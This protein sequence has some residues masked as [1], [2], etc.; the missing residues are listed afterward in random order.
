MLR[1]S[2]TGYGLVA[3]TFHWVIALMFLGQAGLGFYMTG[4]EPDD[5][6]IFPLY[7]WHKSLGLLILLLALLRLAWR[8]VGPLPALPAAMADWEKLAARLAHVALYAALVAIP[9]TGWAL[10]S[11]SPLNIPT[12]AFNLVVVPHLPVPVSDASEASWTFVHGLLANM[13]LAIALVHVAAAFRHEFILRDGL[14][15]RMVRPARR[16]G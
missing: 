11:A 4:L 9:L 12:F 16:G 14:L 13:A 7:Q 10:V 15:A 1:N 8:L 2:E 3:I 5:P 6:L